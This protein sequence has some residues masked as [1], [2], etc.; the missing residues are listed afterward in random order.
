MRREAVTTSSP[1]L[2]ETF[3]TAVA[4]RLTPSFVSLGGQHFAGEA[5]YDGS[6]AVP[7]LKAL[8]Y[9]ELDG[10]FFWWVNRFT[11]GGTTLDIAYGDREFLIQ[12]SLSYAGVADRFAP[13]ELL[14]A[15]QAPNPHAVSGHDC[16]FD[17]GSI[18]R[19]VEQLAEG[20]QQHWSI[21]GTPDPQI[22]DRACV[23][24]VER[25]L[26][27][28]AEQRRLDR[29]RASIQASAAFHAGRYAEAIRLLEPFRGD[30]E[31][32]RSSTKLL[33]LAELRLR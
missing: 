2:V 21:L 33:E 3:D 32:A 16:L 25:R 29:E 19:V 26:F 17:P 6:S 8:P 1:R 20:I 24:R 23:L 27:A 7:A 18:I 12:A 14:H 10:R 13:W 30:A 28:Q 11:V 5:C 9:E 15:A 22:I 31:L 4:E